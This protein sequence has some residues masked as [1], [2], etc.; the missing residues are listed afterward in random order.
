MLANAIVYNI[1]TEYFITVNIQLLNLPNPS[2][3]VIVGVADIG[4][5]TVVVDDG[6]TVIS[7]VIVLENIPSRH[8]LLLSKLVQFPHLVGPCIQC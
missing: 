6:A 8:C 5:I 2:R 3:F 1:V 4:T 7:F